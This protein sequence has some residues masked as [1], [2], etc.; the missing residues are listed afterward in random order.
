MYYDCK[1]STLDKDLANALSSM[2]PE[3]SWMWVMVGVGNFP[4][5]VI[6][7]QNAL[8]SSEKL[9]IITK[10][11]PSAVMMLDENYISLSIN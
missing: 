10:R 3:Y 2:I 11:M 9:E 5:F 4:T 8:L 7:S 1:R 6:I